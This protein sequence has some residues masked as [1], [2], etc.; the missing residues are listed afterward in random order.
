MGKSLTLNEVIE[1]LEEHP[2]FMD[3]AVNYLSRK[4]TLS[5]YT[6]ASSVT[7]ILDY[8]MIEGELPFYECGE[9]QRGK[10]ILDAL[11]Y[12]DLKGDYQAGMESLLNTWKINPQDLV[13]LIQQEGFAQTEL[14]KSL[15]QIESP[16]LINHAETEPKGRRNN[17][18]DSIC[19]IAKQLNY[20]DLM[21]IPEGGKAAIKIECLK[22]TAL[23]TPDGF[24]QAWQ[25]ANRRELISMQDKEK[26]L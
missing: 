8:W 11:V 7:A 20:V 19:K 4:D 3:W 1:E 10:D 21:A 6:Q 14:L 5:T 2:D 26:Y 17:Q 24:K 9:L 13:A 22:I 25:E 15:V 23:F 12:P 16:A 18:I